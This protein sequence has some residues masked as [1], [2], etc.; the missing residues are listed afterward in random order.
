[1]SNEITNCGLVALR[2]FTSLKDVSIRTLMLMAEDNGLKLYP[3]KVPLTEIEKIKFPAI[4]HAENHFVFANKSSELKGYSF[5]GNVLLTEKSNYQKIPVRQQKY[6]MGASGAIVGIGLSAVSIGLGVA[7]G[8]KADKAAKAAQAKIEPYKTPQEVYD[9]LNA[10]QANAGSGFDATTL[11]YL[12]NQ[13]D[14]AFAGSLATAQRIGADPNALSAIFGQKID[15]I[16]EVGAQNHAM[17][18]Q[19]F[20]AYINALNATGASSAAEQK[21]QQDL[22]KDQLQKI[23][24]D[25]AIAAGQISQ[26][27]NA[28]I[29][30]IANSQM[31]KLYATNNNN[32]A[33]TTYTPQTTNSTGYIPPAV[34][35]TSQ[36]LR[37]SAPTIK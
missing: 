29:A 20:S 25:K 7:K 10:T 4:F 17:Q 16:M 11:D 31:A 12:N 13:S 26:G 27:I 23:A 37:V 35:Q 30:G 33:Q 5:T 19:N 1:M 3:Y 36:G 14:S 2:Q 15:G 34:T 18:M 6:V 32:V 22:L 28:G 21:S 24:N 8:I 9:V